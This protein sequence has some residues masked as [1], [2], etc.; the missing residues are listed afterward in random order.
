MSME[1]IGIQL[2]TDRLALDALAERLQTPLPDEPRILLLSPG[3]FMPRTTDIIIL[4][5][6]SVQLPE[7][8]SNS[9]IIVNA[10]EGPFTDE[11]LTGA[12]AGA[13]LLRRQEAKQLTV[14]RWGLGIAGA[15]LA[16]SFDGYVIAHNRPLELTGW[17][18][19]T[20]GGIMMAVSRL[21][22]RADIPPLDDVL[23][24]PIRV[25]GRHE[26]AS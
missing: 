9:D 16:L 21:P 17:G 24:R 3:Q 7:W 1:A 19:A 23:A 22:A 11:A 2:T 26:P 18:V 14:G 5:P 8:R 6:R 10:P 20:A 13:L 25:A 15:G 12:L 4:G